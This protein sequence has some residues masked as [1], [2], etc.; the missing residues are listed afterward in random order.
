MA[1]EAPAPAQQEETPAAPPRPQGEVVSLLPGAVAGSH[2][3]RDTSL[4][5]LAGPATEKQF[6]T[7]RPALFPI[8]C[9]RA[10]DMN[11]EFASSFPLPDL[12]QGMTALKIIF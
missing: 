9:W 12:V 11:F 6:N 3:P 8:A 10:E 2:P 5:V 7:I 1:A 4:H